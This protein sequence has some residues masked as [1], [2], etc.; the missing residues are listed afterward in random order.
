MNFSGIEDTTAWTRKTADLTKLLNK[1]QQ[2]YILRGYEYLHYVIE[3]KVQPVDDCSTDLIL[4]QLEI[5]ISAFSSDEEYDSSSSAYSNAMSD[6]F[7]DFYALTSPNN[8]LYV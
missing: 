8:V 1:S 5:F 2:A 6:M 4:D 3:N 7:E